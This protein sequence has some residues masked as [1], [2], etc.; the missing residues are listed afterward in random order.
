MRQLE[1]DLQQARSRQAQ[2]QAELAEYVQ[3]RDVLRTR[4]ASVR[5]GRERLISLLRSGADVAPVPEVLD[6]GSAE[7]RA[8]ARA[9]ALGQIS[10][11]TREEIELLVELRVA[12]AELAAELDAALEVV[13]ALATSVDELVADA[14]GEFMNLLE[15]LLSGDPG[16]VARDF[17]EDALA[18]RTREML[19]A[20]DWPSSELVEHLIG[21][22]AGGESDLDALAAAL[23]ETLRGDEDVA[24]SSS[25]Q[26]AIVDFTEAVSALDVAD[27]VTARTAQVT[28]RIRHTWIGD[29]RIWIEHGA[30]TQ[31]LHDRTGG[32]TDD[33]VGSW[34]VQL[35]A[36]HDGHGR[37]RL[38]V[39]DQANQDIGT[40]LGW[41]LALTP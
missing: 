10:N 24:L 40:L 33:L 2:V 6:A 37:W 11:A 5:E 3:R 29:L 16:A 7:A 14:R 39:A 23:R 35:P 26:L 21:T 34:T 22:R 36:G 30:F 28:V 4:I 12:A 20:L 32:D 9:E 13:R 31:V 15:G 25:V 38:H 27:H 19:A 18:R 17:L 41:D 8:F 1:A